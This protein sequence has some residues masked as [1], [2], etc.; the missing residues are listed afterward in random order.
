[1]VA[2]GF[3]VARGC[4]HEKRFHLNAQQNGMC[5]AGGCGCMAF[6]AVPEAPGDIEVTVTGKR[7]GG[8]WCLRDGTVAGVGYG[9][10][11]LEAF[12][13]LAFS[14]G[15]GTGQ[16]GDIAL[17][18]E[19]AAAEITAAQEATA[20]W[21]RSAEEWRRE[22]DVALGQRRELRVLLEGHGGAQFLPH[23]Q[24]AVT[25]ES[26]AWPREAECQVG[27]ID[28]RETAT[29]HLARITEQEKSR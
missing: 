29:E 1:M 4:G 8:S 7:R 28:H 2:V 19:A 21:R 14:R 12:E 11:L 18:I 15:E 3:C 24:A 10:T 6:V 26:P 5:T 22:R 20:Q 27:C 25:A 13:D 16:R 23:E 17:V 9:S